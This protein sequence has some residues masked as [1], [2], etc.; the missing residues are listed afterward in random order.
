MRP[1]P[2]LRPSQGAWLP[3]ARAPS[4]TGPARFRF[5]SVDGELTAPGDWDRTDWPRLWRYNLHYFDDLVAQGAGGR[6]PWHR[7]LIDCPSRSCLT[8]GTSSA[9]RCTTRRCSKICSTWCSWARAGRRWWANRSLRV[10][11]PPRSG[12]CAGRGG[13]T[14]GGVAQR[15]GGGGAGLFSG[16]AGGEDGGSHPKRGHS[17]CTSSSMN[18][19]ISPIHAAMTAAPSRSVQRAATDEHDPPGMQRRRIRHTSRSLRR[20][21]P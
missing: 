19:S 2:S 8:A 10:G 4:M 14:D 7:V 15:V 9:A 13:G 3:C 17:I 16:P 18:R 21:P 11:A 1:A 5:L 20:G 12:C 6:A